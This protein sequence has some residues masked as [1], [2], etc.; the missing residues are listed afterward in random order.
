MAQAIY[1]LWLAKPT[2]AWY[3]LS[4]EE[5]NQLLAKND[6]VLKEAGGERVIVCNSEWAAEQWS[7]WGVEKF[8]S[9]EALQKHT[10]L[11]S[12]LSWFRYIESMT[13]LGSEPQM[14]QA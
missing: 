13:I 6:E 14:P 1:K 4:Q 11:L 2:E 7:L 12:E 5:H 3:Q 8:P 10:Q 9:L